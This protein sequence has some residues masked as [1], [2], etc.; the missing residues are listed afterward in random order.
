MEF[1]T[2]QYITDSRFGQ[3]YSYLSTRS[4]TISKN[5]E[6][7]LTILLLLIIRAKSEEKE[8]KGH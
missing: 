6:D 5:I 7:V 4:M 8:D 3:N 1:Y 2:R